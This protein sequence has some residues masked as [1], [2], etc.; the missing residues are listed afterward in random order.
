MDCKYC[1]KKLRFKRE[2]WKY[3][4]RFSLSVIMSKWEDKSV[5]RMDLDRYDIRYSD[6]NCKDLCWI[7]EFS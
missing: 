5:K 7:A 3:Y 6:C 1:G 4:P 2:A